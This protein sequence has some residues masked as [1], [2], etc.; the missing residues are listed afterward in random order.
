MR[1][2]LVLLLA[3]ST[4][5]FAASPTFTAPSTESATD[6]R[7]NGD[8]IVIFRDSSAAFAAFTNNV[9]NDPEVASFMNQ[10]F[11]VYT[12]ETGS[13]EAAALPFFGGSRME[14]RTVIVAP[15]LD[16]SAVF[17]GPLSSKTNFL[18]LLRAVNQAKTREDVFTA[19]EGLS[20]PS[21][22]NMIA[23]AR[24]FYPAMVEPGAAPE[25]LLLGFLISRDMKVLNHSVAIQ[26]RTPSMQELRRMFPRADI[27][28]RTDN[29]ASCF[30][31][32][33]PKEAKYCVVWAL[34]AK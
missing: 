19:M 4:L 27:P 30:G 10:N 23:W 20:G 2:A 33:N 13:A 24:E 16:N 6:Q 28:D 3:F 8:R 29:G 26:T 1:R 22:D 34:V 31:G 12:V 32:V 21:A 18:A 11:A 7:F 14:P 25:G 15:R 5:C 17:M 9:L